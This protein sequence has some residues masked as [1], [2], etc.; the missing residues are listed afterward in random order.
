MVKPLRLLDRVQRSLAGKRAGEAKGGV[1]LVSSGGL[2]DTVLFALVLPRF[3]ALA[4]GGEMVTVQLRHDA[5]RMAFLL[6]PEVKVRTVDYGRYRRQAAYRWRTNRGLFA[7]NFRLVISCDYLRHPHLDEAMVEAAVA[8]E[9]WAMVARPWTKYDRHLEQNRRLYT[10]LLESG[11]PHLDKVVRWARF[12]N[13]LAGEP[14]AA[15]EPPPRVELPAA[16]LPAAARLDRPVVVIQPFS[17]VAEKQSPVEL[18]RRII[19]SLPAGTGV[20]VTGA[21]GDMERNPQ[22]KSLLNKKG[23]TLDTSSFGDVVPL[24]RAARLV[25]S[26]D[27]A[28]MHLSVAV[29][30]PTLCLASSAYVDEIVPYDAAISPAN[31]HFIHHPMPCAG[32]L[33]SCTRPAEKGMWPC[34]ARLDGDRIVEK[35]RGLVAR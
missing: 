12:A 21:P 31:A 13:E 3:L 24:L 29:G 2:G 9:T 35:V 8:A 20:V 7:A 22:F 33:G 28:L 17:A 32:C 5:A 26:V 27:T 1:L 10:R 23:V 4:G 14:A 6:P 18:Y 25:V 15:G 34:V 19:D 16:G 30:A 11:P